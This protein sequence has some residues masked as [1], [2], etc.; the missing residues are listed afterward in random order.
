MSFA[1]I[2]LCIA[3][4]QAFIIVVVISLSTQFENFW[5][6]PCK[7]WFQA[8]I[9]TGHSRYNVTSHPSR[10]RQRWFPTH[11]IILKIWHRW[12][13]E[14]ILLSLVKLVKL[15]TLFLLSVTN[16]VFHMRV[17]LYINASIERNSITRPPERHRPTP[18]WS[19]HF[20]KCVYLTSLQVHAKS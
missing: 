14:R 17:T 5:I 12:W 18:A 20:S 6:H 10:C 9:Y 3:F 2:T 7:Y 1:T 11:W 4:Q 13:P 16:S 8:G 19:K 15:Y